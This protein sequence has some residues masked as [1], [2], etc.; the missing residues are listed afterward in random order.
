MSGTQRR[1]GMPRAN[2][3]HLLPP[4]QHH[5]RPG[6][7]GPQGEPNLG[8]VSGEGGSRS[9]QF[10]QSTLNALVWEMNLG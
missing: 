5:T 2:H 4:P 7:L 6:I 10:N 1:G 3:L 8:L 9:T